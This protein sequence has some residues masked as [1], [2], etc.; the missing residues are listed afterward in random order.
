MKIGLGDLKDF[1]HDILILGGR[2]NDHRRAIRSFFIL[3][4]WLHLLGREVYVCKC[5]CMYECGYI[6]GREMEILCTL[7]MFIKL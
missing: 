1:A 6:G 7:G 5:L 3:F 4:L 2:Q